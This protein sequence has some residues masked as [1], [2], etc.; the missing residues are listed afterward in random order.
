MKDAANVIEIEVENGTYKV[1]KPGG[2]I[3]V[4]FMGIVTQITMETSR[5]TRHLVDKDLNEDPE[6]MKKITGNPEFMEAQV[7]ALMHGFEVFGEKVLPQLKIEGPFT[8]EDMPGEDQYGIFMALF[9]S[10][11]SKESPFRIL[12]PRYSTDAGDAG[13]GTGHPTLSP[14]GVERAK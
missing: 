14:G 6:V 2:H 10:M 11:K 12:T 9:Y 3:G 5:N 8:F 4:I 13:E 1:T 7:N